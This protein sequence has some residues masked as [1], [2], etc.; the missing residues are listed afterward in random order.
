[1]IHCY[2]LVVIITCTCMYYVISKMCAVGFK[3][4]QYS[5]R[6]RV[7]CLDVCMCTVHVV[8]MGERRGMEGIPYPFP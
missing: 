3:T 6:G 5:R 1:M 8:G 4:V 2:S 7:E